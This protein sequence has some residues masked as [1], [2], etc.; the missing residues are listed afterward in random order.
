MCSRYVFRKYP[1]GGF[2]KK[3]AL[4]RKLLLLAIKHVNTPYSA[5]TTTVPE[6][7]CTGPDLFRYAED[8]GIALRDISDVQEG[9]VVVCSQNKNWCDPT[10]M[11]TVKIASKEGVQ[12]SKIKGKGKHA[13][14]IFSYLLFITCMYIID[15][16]LLFIT[17]HPDGTTANLFVHPYDKIRAPAKRNFKSTCAMLVCLTCLCRKFWIVCLFCML[18]S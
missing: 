10:T 7:I 3:S 15:S 6:G 12:L 1:G 17:E 11:G 13:Y 16:Y 5:M 2:F 4:A 9:D 14:I 18:D 8:N